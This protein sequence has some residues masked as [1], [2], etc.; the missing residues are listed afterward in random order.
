MFAGALGLAPTAPGGI[1]AVYQVSSGETMENLQA[2]TEPTTSSY[3]SL[4]AQPWAP[5]GAELLAGNALYA[6]DACGSLAKLQAAAASRIAWAQPLSAGSDHPP[7]TDP[8]H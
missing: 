4:P 5:D 2:V 3:R 7:A 8:Y 1:A 6:C